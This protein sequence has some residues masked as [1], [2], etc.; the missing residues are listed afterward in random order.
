MQLCTQGKKWDG[1]VL[2]ETKDSKEE[3]VKEIILSRLRQPG[4]YLVDGEIKDSG[5]ISQQWNPLYI[6]TSPAK[7]PW[8]AE[9][10]NLKHYIDEIS[11]LIYSDKTFFEKEIGNKKAV[12]S[13]TYHNVHNVGQNYIDNI[14]QNNSEER[15]QGFNLC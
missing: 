14:L 1:R 15:G 6:S 5:D 13:S 4:M 8:I 10:F 7:V 9:W 3:D 11:R 2:D 12:I